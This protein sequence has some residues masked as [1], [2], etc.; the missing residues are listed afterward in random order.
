MKKSGLFPLSIKLF[1]IRDVVRLP[2][3]RYDAAL[4]KKREQTR[5][6]NET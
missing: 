2:P 5:Y 3:S 4:T 6:V 1:S